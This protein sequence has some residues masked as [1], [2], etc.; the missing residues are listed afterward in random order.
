MVPIAEFT[1]DSIVEPAPY[2]YANIHEAA[3]ES[4]WQQL[5]SIPEINYVVVSASDECL[6]IQVCDI[7]ATKQHGAERLQAILKISH[8]DTLAIGDGDNDLAL[9]EVADYRVAMANATTTLKDN[10]TYITESV[11]DAGWSTAMRHFGL[12]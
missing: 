9:F 12:I 3:K 4:L 1:L 11:D 6:D 10:A 2:V 8:E 5:S 7:A